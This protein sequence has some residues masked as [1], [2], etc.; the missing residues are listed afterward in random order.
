MSS[1]SPSVSAGTAGVLTPGALHGTEFPHVVPGQR[2]DWSF[3]PHELQF[4]LGYYYENITS[5]HYCMLGDAD[6]FFRTILMS[7]AIRNEALLYAVVG[8]AAYHHALNNPNG[9]INEFLQYYNRSVSLLLSFLKKKEK[10]NV[11]TLLTILQLATIEVG[12]SS[13]REGGHFRCLTS[14]RSTWAI[15]STSPATRERP[16]RYWFSYLPRR[17]S[18]KHPLVA[19]L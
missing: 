18:S 5:Y 13:Y 11:T 1:S 15:G 3:L 7:V 4:Y 12:V 10:H 16:S 8:F 6:D 9:Q 2:L 19:W 14:S 17:R